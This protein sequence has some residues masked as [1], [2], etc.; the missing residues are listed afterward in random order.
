MII[1]YLFETIGFTFDR[2]IWMLKVYVNEARVWAILPAFSVGGDGA[3]H[4]RAEDIILSP[5]I[6]VSSGSLHMV[7]TAPKITHYLCCSLSFAMPL[8]SIYF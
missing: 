3:K 4:D 2:G 5:F 1:H 6:P 7:T 8:T